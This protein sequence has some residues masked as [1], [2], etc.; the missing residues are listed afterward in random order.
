M[1][2]VTPIKS[3]DSVEVGDEARIDIESAE[4]W[5]LTSMAALGQA[6]LEHQE[7]KLRYDLAESNLRSRSAT[8]RQ[9]EEQ[10]AQVLSK[11]AEL[12]DLGEGEWT[13]DGNGKMVRKVNSNV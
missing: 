4:G 9:S 12:I 6:C 7:A 8:A 1:A 11:I 2:E 13:Y 3:P 5:V 10:R